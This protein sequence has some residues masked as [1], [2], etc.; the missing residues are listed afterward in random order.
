MSNAAADMNPYLKGIFA[1]VRE[2]VTADNLPVIGEI[3]RDL[4]GAY[5]R[6]GPNPMSPPKGMHHWFDGDGMVHGV[7]F[8][9][10]SARYANR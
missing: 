9:N 4:Y 8:E 7:W 6:N 10:G 5:F 2:E 3:P 1:P